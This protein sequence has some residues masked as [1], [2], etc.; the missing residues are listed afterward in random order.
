MVGLHFHNNRL[1]SCEHI[2]RGSEKSTLFHI[3]GEDLWEYDIRAFSKY[4]KEKEI[5][6]EPE[7][8]VRVD[9]VAKM[10]AAG[11]NL[12][13]DVTLQKFE[14]LVLEDVIPAKGV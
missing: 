11:G 2:H 13:I 12:V 6:L 4:I 5:L 9:D 7:A 3:S 8:K 14:H 10:G 1:R